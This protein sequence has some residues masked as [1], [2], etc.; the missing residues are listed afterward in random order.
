MRRLQTHKL[1]TVVATVSL[2]AVIIL[3]S[4][5]HGTAADDDIESLEQKAFQAAVHRVAPSVVRIETIGGRDRLGKTLLG[6]GPTTGLIVSEDGLILSSQFNFLRRPDSILVQ[7][8]DGSRTLARLVATDHGRMVV[9]LKIDAKAPHP[10]PEFAPRDTMRV[11]QWAIAVGRTFR[12]DGPNLSVGILSALSRIRGRAIQTDAATSPNNYG[13]P[14]LDI[15]GRV[16]GLLTPLSPDPDEEVGRLEWYDSGI[17]FAVPAEDL[18]RVLPRLRRGEDLYPGLL[19]VGFAE[20]DPNTAEPVIAVCHPQSPGYGVLKPGDRITAV[21]GQ[22]VGRVAQLQNALGRY[23]AGDK[24]T[25]SVLREGKEREHEFTLLA[26]LPLYQRPFLGILPSRD[27]ATPTDPVTV[28]FVYPNSPASKVGMVA[29]DVLLSMAGKKLADADDLRRRVAGLLSDDEVAIVVR[30]KGKSHPLSV[31]L[32]PLSETLPDED[33]PLSRDGKNSTTAKPSGRGKV[34]I[35]LPE[36]ENKAWAYV[37]TGYDSAV[38]HGVMVWLD[39]PGAVDDDDILK[40]WQPVCD[41]RGLILLVVK[42]V[43]PN[44][45]LP[46][47]E[48]VVARMLDELINRY[49]VDSQRVVVHGYQGGGTLA[50]LVAFRHRDLVRAVAVVDAPLATRPPAPEPIHPLAFYLITA[51]KSPQAVRIQRSIKA[52]REAKVPLE[53]QSVDGAPRYLLPDEVDRLGKWIDTLDRI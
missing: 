22:P 51:E 5:A 36:V 25:V 34:T 7:L 53:R 26:E 10:I 6:T 43:V 50:S 52:L 39:G 12:V 14:L 37:P 40:L 20:P 28:R 16:L 44:A 47:E 33:L 48:E 41:E 49:T 23:Y 38:G 32:R 4:L 31:E 45:W 18:M 15:Q 46:N 17:G 13:G 42:P 11:G 19:G 8:P 35:G 2:V 1:T 29:G 27:P 24:V 9:L 3:Q 21:N 30:R